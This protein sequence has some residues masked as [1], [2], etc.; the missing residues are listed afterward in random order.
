VRSPRWPASHELR[1]GTLC[2][3]GRALGHT[4]TLLVGAYSRVP[5]TAVDDIEQ[6]LVLIAA[7]PG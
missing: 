1:V 3:L 6:A 4:P 5:H 7:G 2:T